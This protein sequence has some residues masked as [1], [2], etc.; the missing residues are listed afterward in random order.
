MHEAGLTQEMLKIV[1]DEASNAGIAR[2]ARITLRLG[3]T[4]PAAPDSISLYFDTFS[5]GTPAEGAT[6][7]FFPTDGENYDFQ[8]ESIEGE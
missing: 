5:K 4:S 7:S 6:L 8:V 2:V 3:D 1:L